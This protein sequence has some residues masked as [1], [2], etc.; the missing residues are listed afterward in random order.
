[1]SEYHF[2]PTAPPALANTNAFANISTD[3]KIYVPYSADHS[4]LEAYKTETNWSS[5]ASKMQEEPA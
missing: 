3:C 5:Y 4:I 2:K 1:M